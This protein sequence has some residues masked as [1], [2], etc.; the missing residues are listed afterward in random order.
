MKTPTLAMLFLAVLIVGFAIAA[1]KRPAH[2]HDIYSDWRVP[3]NPAVSCCNNSDCRPTRAY[4]EDDG[5]WRA[6]DGHGWLVVPAE[7][8]LPTDL[9]KDGRAHLCEKGGWIYCFSPSE[10]KS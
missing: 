1:I 9:A 5:L 7:R 3:N 8:L 2:G 6:W 10:P 4:K